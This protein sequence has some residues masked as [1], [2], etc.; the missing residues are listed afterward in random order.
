[1]SHEQVAEHF[2]RYADRFGLR[3]SIRF[4]SDVVAVA[5]DGD[6]WNVTVAPRDGGEPLVR[7][8][9]RVILANGHLTHPKMP[10][11][12]GTFAGEAI[13][14]HHYKVADPFDDKRVL[15]VGIGNSAVDIAV[16]LARRAR[17]VLLS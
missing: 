17:S 14:S 9:R 2:D 3:E 10:A 8:Y 11:F 6:G 13:H 15:V 12:E 4:R 7:R 16:D 1:L 5:P